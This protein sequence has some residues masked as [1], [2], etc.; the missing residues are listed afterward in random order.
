ME[1]T[2]RQAT[3]RHYLMCPPTH[4]DVTY[5]INP[6][7][8]PGKPADRSIAVDQ[9]QRI[10]DQLV[11]LGHA[12]DI[13]PPLEGL[14]DMVFAANGATVYG[15]RALVARFRFP[16]RDAESAEYL[17]WFA[18]KG[19]KVR[20]ATLPNE[21]EGD[22]L[23]AGPWLLAG[24]GFRTDR[25]SHVE[26]EEYFGRPVVGLT[27]VNDKFY[28][29]DTALAV[30]DDRTIM[31]Y[32]GA[33]TPGSQAI[34][35]ELFPTAIR[36]GYEDAEAFGLNAVSDGK[37][38]LMPEG[39]AGLTAQLRDAGFETFGMD[40][41]ELLLAGGGVKCCTLELHDQSAIW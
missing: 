4:F 35:R 23:A 16:E 10:H 2:T 11:G 5:S 41:S 17:D 21:G 18:A 30:L 13:V 34:L 22:Y 31:Y 20:Q 37:H 19:L 38:V 14:P 29:L 24:N 32:P 3:A 7:M 39:A 1:K 8:D 40:V 25:R 15:D 26:S 36:A 9:W 28:H 6:W 27:L 33:F 12:V